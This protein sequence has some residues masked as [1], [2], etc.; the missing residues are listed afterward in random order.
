MAIITERSDELLEGREGSSYRLSA[1]LYNPT[2]VEN[3]KE[4][5]KDKQQKNNNNK[6][7]KWSSY[8]TSEYVTEES[9]HMKET[10]ISCHNS[11]D[12]D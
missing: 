6:K 2:I 12:M 3:Y 8:P 7:I 9:H 1:D 5:P 4:S 11:K 10:L